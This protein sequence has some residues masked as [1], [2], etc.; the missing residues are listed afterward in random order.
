MQ[1]GTQGS[2][3][4]KRGRVARFN[5]WEIGSLQEKE[6]SQR[7]GFALYN[8]SLCSRPSRQ[9]KLGLDPSN[10]K[11]LCKYIGNMHSMISKFD[12]LIT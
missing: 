1:Q 11:L 7:G 12:I 6:E 10:P 9:P 4:G 3:H 2:L 8:G 5:E